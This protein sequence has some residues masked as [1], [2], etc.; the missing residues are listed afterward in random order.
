MPLARVVSDGQGFAKAHLESEALANMAQLSIASAAAAHPLIVSVED[1]LNGNDVVRMAVNAASVGAEAPASGIVSVNDPDARDALLSP[2]SIGLIPQL[3]ANRGLCGQLMPTTIGVRRF[4]A[5]QV[6]ADICNK[7]SVNC[8]DPNRPGATRTTNYVKGKILEYEISWYPLG[9][10]LGELLNTITLAPC[11][12][13]AVAVSDWM[14]RETASR[15]EASLTQEETTQHIDHDRLIVETLDSTV[16]TKSL[17]AG[18]AGSIGASFPIKGVNV[19]AAVGGGISGSISSQQVAAS[20]SS[21]LA[22][23][24][25]QAATLVLSYRSSV[26]FQATASERRLY[27]TRVVR[28]HN[29]CH[30]LTLMY[31]QVTQNYRVVID[32]L[33]ERDAILIEYPSPDFD[34]E[35]AYCNAPVLRDAL[36][37]KSLDKCFD[38]LGDALFCCDE[39]AP[40]QTT[41]MDSITITANVAV[42]AHIAALTVTLVTVNGP[43]QLPPFPV[44]NWQ[45]GTHTQTLSLPSPID[46]SSVTSVVIFTSS[47]PFGVPFLLLNQLAITYHAIG[48]ANPL[49]L[50]SSQSPIS[51]SHAWSSDVKAELPPPPPVKN[52]CIERSCCAKKLVGH[53]NCHKRRYN[54]AIW[55][56]EEPNERVVRWS[57]CKGADGDLI[58]LIENAPLAVYGD[59]VVFPAAGSTLVDD[60]AVLPVS[61]L[62]TIPTPGVYAEGILGQC[63][64]CEILDPQRD[65]DWK[66]CDDTAQLPDFPAPQSGTTATDLKPEAITNQINLTGVPDAPDSVLKTLLET[67]LSGAKSGSEESKAL[68]DKLFDVIKESLTAK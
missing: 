53:L 47:I 38:E 6:R 63:N 31:Y 7:L 42:N 57:C 35:R 10:A 33:G 52:E 56:N 51:L 58:G 11:E 48:A 50:F 26:V 64:T 54:E 18:L 39:K 9:S 67:L 28:N 5:F 40:A 25:T 3:N 20:T 4:R 13:V 65:T 23:H 22:E 60:P 30:T 29:K 45:P 68:L 12:Q 55:L 49:S 16:D 15:Q 66:C 34:A 46:P 1:L 19:T 8:P 14:R 27:Q 59:F 41:L 32:Y 24:I 2:G 21:H 17:A 36:L 44:L 43:I 62:V 37:D 61:R